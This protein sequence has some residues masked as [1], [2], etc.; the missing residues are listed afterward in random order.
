MI[1]PVLEPFLAKASDIIHWQQCHDVNTVSGT[2]LQLG[3][4]RA[5][6]QHP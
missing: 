2:E 6:W 4:A 1:F 5:Y 3:A